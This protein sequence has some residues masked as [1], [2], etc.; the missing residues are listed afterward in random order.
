MRQAQTARTAKKIPRHRHVQQDTP[1][2]VGGL[3]ERVAD[4]DLD[5]A[6]VV[7]SNFHMCETHAVFR[8]Q[9]ALVGG[10]A[11]P[12]RQ[13]CP[14]FPAKDSERRIWHEAADQ[15][16]QAADKNVHKEANDGNTSGRG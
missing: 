1:L 16:A 7:A 14:P 5:V 3:I 6:A 12:G 10:A 4:A 13:L 9:A 8:A 11:R 15:Q 2:V